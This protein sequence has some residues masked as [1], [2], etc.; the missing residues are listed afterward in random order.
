MS[1]KR[2]DLSAP[3]SEESIIN[4]RCRNLESLFEAPPIERPTNETEQK[5]DLGN[6]N[7]TESL[8]QAN[9]RLSIAANRA[10]E[11][12]RKNYQ[13]N[14]EEDLL[15]EDSKE[16]VEF[17][18]LKEEELAEASEEYEWETE[19]QLR[20]VWPGQHVAY[21]PYVEY[22]HSITFEEIVD[23]IKKSKFETSIARPE[24][25]ANKN[26]NYIPNV[27]ME[28]DPDFV[29]PSSI[30]SK[31]FSMGE[32]ASRPYNATY[33]VKIYQDKDQLCKIK[34]YKQGPRKAYDTT[35]VSS[36]A[37][38]LRQQGYEHVNITL[39]SSSWEYDVK[40]SKSNIPV[41][42]EYSTIQNNHPYCQRFLY[43]MNTNLY[44]SLTEVVY[45]TEDSTSVVYYTSFKHN[46]IYYCIWAP[47]RP[48]DVGRGKFITVERDGEQTV[49]YSKKTVLPK[50]E[51]KYLNIKPD[52]VNRVIPHRFM[53]GA[54]LRYSTYIKKNIVAAYYEKLE[55]CGLVVIKS[56]V[57]DDVCFDKFIHPDA[58]TSSQRDA[59]RRGIVPTGLVLEPVYQ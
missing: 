4:Q 10:W 8:Q 25:S 57:V 22:S 36:L 18:K 19:A 2:L 14:F 49:V 3:I 21:A 52:N 58:M 45:K 50:I 11:D 35:S 1:N 44:H 16:Y 42:D 31:N 30:V 43:L 24:H 40:I 54:I 23:S 9:Y 59:L 26:D 55:K 48:E 53:Y 12:W 33:L 34:E 13:G 17:K 7:P 41:L 56:E 27:G 6:L 39:L 37:Y 28:D 38:E 20:E 51:R 29:P 32:P 46:G 5:S 47:L 15:G